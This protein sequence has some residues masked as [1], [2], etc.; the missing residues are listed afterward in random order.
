MSILNRERFASMLDP[1]IFQVYEQLIEKGED[2]IP[3]V[4]GIHNSTLSQETVT[5]I[6]ATG[7]MQEWQGQVYYDDVNPLWNKTYV[8]KKY[9]L[10]LK[11][12][13]DLWDDAQHPEIKDR[14]QRVTL[15]VHRSRQIHAHSIF[16]NAFNSSYPGPDG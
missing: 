11:I 7:L 10:G 5:G 2:I 13:R 6:G 1:V 15:S 8:H 3:K 16:N 9:S 14:I 4:Y 12:D